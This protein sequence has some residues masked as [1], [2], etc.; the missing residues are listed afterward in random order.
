VR[1]QVELAA[2]TLNRKAIHLAKKLKLVYF[3]YLIKKRVIVIMEPAV[4]ERGKIC[5][6]QWLGSP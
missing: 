1:S 5:R 4:G 2:A 6:L 3:Q